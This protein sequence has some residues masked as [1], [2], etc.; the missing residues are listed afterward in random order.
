MPAYDTMTHDDF[1]N[2]LLDIVKGMTAQE[3]LAYP[4]IYEILAEE[5]NNTVLEKW[6]E[7]HTNDNIPEEERELV[8]CRRCNCFIDIAYG[9]DEIAAHQDRE[10]SYDDPRAPGDTD[11]ICDVCD[12]RVLR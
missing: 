3:L 8:N 2:G 9:A 4:G 10:G 6:E 1:Y 7:A 11:D 5:L 12:Y